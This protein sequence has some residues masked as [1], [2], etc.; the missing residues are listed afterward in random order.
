MSS[1]KDQHG[2]LFDF[3][4]DC[5]LKQAES[6]LWPLLYIRD[7]SAL[8]IGAQTLMMKREQLMR[9]TKSTEEVEV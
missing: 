3:S 1:L 5:Y 7:G 4:V 6:L 8:S 2:H 9:F